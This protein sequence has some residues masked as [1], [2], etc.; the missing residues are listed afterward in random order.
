MVRTI[1]GITALLCTMKTADAQ[2]VDATRSLH[3]AFENDLIAVRGAGAPPDYD[4]T[5]GTRIGAAWPGAP[6]WIRRISGWLPEC[7]SADARRRGCV[8]TA[9]E[10]GQEI[11]T[12]RRDARVPLAGE[13]P[14]AGWLYGSGTARLVSSG[15][16]RSIRLMVGV[17]GPPALGAEVQNALHRA[18]RNA[19]QLG[20]VHQLSFEPAM[21]V[22]Y[23]ERMHREPS[24]ADR[25][26]VRVGVDWGATIGNLRTGIHAGV[27]G[28]LGLR[29][30]RS[31]IPAEP[32]LEQSMSVYAL[33][34]HRQEIVLRDLFVDGNTFRPSV[35]AVRRVAVGQYHVGFG[36]R[37]R[38]YGIDYRHV[39]RGEEYRAQN[40]RHAHGVL[41]VSVHQ[42]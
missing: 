14:Y 12:P 35:R 32:E 8:M 19:P 4:Y 3:L 22:R 20:W 40:G 18:L 16:V 11:Y 27:D 21:A 30:P 25:R 7:R 28:R 15:R 1:A 10:L 23:D 13:R 34:G 24:F 39:S 33:A 31:W 36:V 2:T 26:L 9:L 6:G 41:V 38:G 17:T 29:G 37:R 5:H 42:F